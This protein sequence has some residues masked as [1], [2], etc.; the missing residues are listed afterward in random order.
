MLWTTRYLDYAVEQLRVLPADRR[1]HDGLDEDVVRL[2]SP[3]EHA[4]AD[5]IVLGC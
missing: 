5:L 3:L 2:L 4:D 1:E